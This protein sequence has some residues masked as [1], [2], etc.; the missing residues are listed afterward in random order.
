MTTDPREF[1]RLR[2][3]ETKGHARALNWCCFQ[4][5]PLLRSD[6]ARR[7]FVDATHRALDRHDVALWAYCIM[8]THVH[9]L[10]FPRTAQPNI[11]AFR[12]S[13][14]RS[15]AAVAL[16]WL[17]EHNS[18]ILPRLLDEQPSGRSSHRFWQRGG[19][20]DRNLWS[21]RHIW[22]MIDY[23]HHN[24]VEAAL[25]TRSIDW[26]WSSAPWHHTRTPGPL[27]IDPTHL[28]PDPRHL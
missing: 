21:P 10:V 17:R 19:G 28:P 6:R 8:P 9:M 14:T 25:C 12:A 16:A 18:T 24:P 2:R 20:Y 22:N 15:S 13:I 5:L 23:I 27:P 3:H 1:K 4:N 26:P 11:G 7:W